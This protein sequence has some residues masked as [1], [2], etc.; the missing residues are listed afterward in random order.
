MIAGWFTRSVN[1]SVDRSTTNVRC[2]LDLHKGNIAFE[3]PDLDGKSELH[4]VTRLDP[5]IC[6]PVVP[7]DHLRQTDSLPVADLLNHP[8][9]VKSGHPRAT[10]I[11]VKLRAGYGHSIH[12]ISPLG[13]TTR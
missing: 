1:G 13:F 6:V 3:I 4:A 11:C 7:L 10:R 12:V 8:R 2:N 9:F 5:P